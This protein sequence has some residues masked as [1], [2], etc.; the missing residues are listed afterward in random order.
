MFN[1]RVLSRPVAGFYTS[2]STGPGRLSIRNNI[3]LVR[4]RYAASLLYIRASLSSEWKINRVSRRYSLFVF[5][6]SP[7]YLPTIT[8]RHKRAA[9][10]RER[11]YCKADNI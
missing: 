1:N 5:C 2:L 9:F 3:I 10:R 11:V 4:I 8:Y 6:S 7:N